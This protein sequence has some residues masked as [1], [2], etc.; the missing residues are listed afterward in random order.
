M[1]KNMDSVP[2]KGLNHL[3]GLTTSWSKALKKINFFLTP[4]VK[5]APPV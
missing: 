4:K 3:L 5:I 2:F 1:L